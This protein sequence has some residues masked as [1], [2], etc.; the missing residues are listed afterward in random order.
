MLSASADKPVENKPLEGM[1]PL[2]VGGK[3]ME[4]PLELLSR[5]LRML[6]R[7]FSPKMEGM[8]H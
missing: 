6:G 1:V 7:M 2:N 8:L 3:R 4:A 5:A